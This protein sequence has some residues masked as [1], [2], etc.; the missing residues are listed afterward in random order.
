MPLWRMLTGRL[1]GYVA[2]EELLLS[3]NVT[4]AGGKECSQLLEA[5][6]Q[7]SGEQCGEAAAGA[8]SSDGPGNTTDQ[9]WL[10]KQR[11][12]AEKGSAVLGPLWHD[13]QPLTTLTTPIIRYADMLLLWQG[14]PPT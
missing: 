14:F 12:C 5:D 1:P 13:E 11:A 2:F 10:A 6:A 7:A 8:A 4:L 9:K 3:V